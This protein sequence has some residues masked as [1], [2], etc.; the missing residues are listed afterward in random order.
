MATYQKICIYCG[1]SF[2]AFHARRKYCDDKCAYQANTPCRKERQKQYRQEQKAKRENLM[3]F[4]Q[5]KDTIDEINEAARQA[6]TSYGKYEAWQQSQKEMAER[7]KERAQGIRFFDRYIK[8][9][10][11]EGAEACQQQ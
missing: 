7:Q 6:G 5:G 1:K 2:E 3:R 4:I 10:W 9:M 8:S 11:K